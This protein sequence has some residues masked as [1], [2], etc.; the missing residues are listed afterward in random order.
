M[1]FQVELLFPGA[2]EPPRHGLTLLESLKLSRAGAGQGEF[3]VI[4]LL[5]PGS[6]ERQRMVEFMAARCGDDWG[7]LRVA[8]RWV[9]WWQASG[10][11]P[12]GRK[13]IHDAM[14]VHFPG[15]GADNNTAVL[16]MITVGIVAPDTL[17]AFASRA[18]ASS[19]DS[20]AR[21]F[22]VAGWR[23]RSAIEWDTL[24]PFSTGEVFRGLITAER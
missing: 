1:D 3:E 11:K 17:P 7:R 2:E 13:L 24:P 8:V 20:F 16:L 23:P 9:R 6:P 18:D 21:A 15:N 10:K 19:A 14:K 5:P 22:A 4:E 12:A